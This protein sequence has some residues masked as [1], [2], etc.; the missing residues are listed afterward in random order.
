MKKGDLAIILVI[1]ILANI[2]GYMVTINKEK[3]AKTV[4]IVRSGEI[5]HRYKFDD[6]YEKIINVDFG[7]QHNVI[8]IKGGK[9]TMTESNCHDKICV[10]TKPISQNGEMIVCLPHKLYVKIEGDEA[11]EPK[12]DEIDIVVN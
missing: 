2:F 6:T 10:K 8:E 11:S 5:L 4:T 12:D 3:S 9:V 7:D 1:F